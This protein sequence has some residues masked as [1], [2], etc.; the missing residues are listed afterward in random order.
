MLARNPQNQMPATRS[1]AVIDG[2]R[3]VLVGRIDDTIQLGELV[4][5][6]PA[7]DVAI[8]TAGVAF[9]NSIGMREWVRLVRTL[10]DRGT[11]LGDY[12]ERYLSVFRA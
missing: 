6:L 2:A 9:V 4:R 12:P 10:R 8:D 1:T 7:G 11:I 5:Q 3:A